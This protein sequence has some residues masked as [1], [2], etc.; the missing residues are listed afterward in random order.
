MANYSSFWYTYYPDNKTL[1]VGFI[2]HL[3]HF[4]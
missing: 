2:V 4:M 3:T 1:N